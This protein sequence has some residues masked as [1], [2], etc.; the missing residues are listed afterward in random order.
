MMTERRPNLIERLIAQFRQSPFASQLFSIVGLVV[1]IPATFSADTYVGL[2]YTFMVIFGVSAFCV[3]NYY[4]GKSA[5]SIA[6]RWHCYHVTP[7]EGTDRNQYAWKIGT[8]YIDTSSSN[9]QI[10][11]YHDE[12][13]RR[14]KLH[15]HRDTGRY[16][17]VER[18]EER[19]IDDCFAY[20]Y[21]MSE[22]V[23]FMPGVWLGP[24]NTRDNRLTTSVYILSRVPLGR[25][26]C[27][28]IARTVSILQP[29]IEDAIW[30]EDDGHV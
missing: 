1:G 16:L 27:L 6:G 15:G 18:R 25:N 21:E 23:E 8:W 17:F 19:E 24:D 12:N 11:G 9:A 20:F 3:V 4:S 28:E 30:P 13:Q 14:Y 5:I 2:L 7:K 26:K 22:D 29:R 10:I